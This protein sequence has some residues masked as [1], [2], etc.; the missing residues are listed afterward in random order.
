MNSGSFIYSIKS[1]VTAMQNEPSL[2]G[3]IIRV[4]FANFL[5]TAVSFIGS[6]VFPRIL[7]IES[8]AQYH[9][10]TLYVSYIAVLHLGFPSGMVI[11]YAGKNVDNINKSQ[12]KSEVLIT[13]YTLS[14]FSVIAIIVSMLTHSKMMLYIA[15]IILP[16]CSVG[17]YRSLLQAWNQFK[18]YSRISM[19]T[20][21]AIPILAFLI[22]IISGGLNGDQYIISYLFVYLCAFIYVLAVFCKTLKGY[23]RNKLFTNDNWETEKTGIAMLAGNYINTLFVSADK[24]FVN[25][26]FS[27]TEFAYYSFG[28]SM[29]SLMTVFITSIAQPLFPAMA[30]GKWKDDDYNSIKELL[31]VFGSFSGCAYFAGSIIVKMFIQKYIPSLQVIEIYFMVFPAM[32]VANCIYVN[33]YKIKQK[34]RIYIKTLIGLLALAIA[35]NFL[36]V[37]T[38]QNYTG[39]AIATIIVYYVWLIIG[40]IQFPFIKLRVKDITYLIVYTAVFIACVRFIT[41]DF[42]G[43][44]IY[45]A[46]IIVLALVCY[47]SNLKKYIKI[48]KARK[49]Q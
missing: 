11:K 37:K 42:L 39:V 46:L 30:Q 26:F 24:Q 17:C 44:F 36:F 4:L 18:V 6:F 2:K 45:G 35:L 32:A 10:F 7:S 21:V 19:L 33:L 38:Y 1:K 25:I 34:M 22:Y 16:Y 31:F 43:L 27:T 47:G 23:K 49:E 12:L 15:L 20:S 41:N 13:F 14:F 48:Y 9:Q 8:Y 40:V 28:M 3:N 29:Q 5:V